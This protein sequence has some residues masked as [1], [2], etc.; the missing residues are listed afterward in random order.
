[1]STFQ[2]DV[3]LINVPLA[4]TEG[5]ANP[6]WFQFFIQL[7]RRTGGAQ[8]S[9]TT[10]LRLSDID[11]DPNSIS[12]DLQS[13]LGSLDETNTLL[14]LNAGDSDAPKL[15]SS[16][17]EASTLIRTLVVD[18]GISPKQANLLSKIVDLLLILEEAQDIAKKLR[19]TIEDTVIDG[20]TPLDPIRSMG[21]QDAAKVTISGGS[22]DGTSIGGNTQAAG[23]FT[24]LTT[25]G[26]AAVA[27]TPSAWGSGY[28]AIEVGLQGN[29]YFS[30]TGGPNYDSLLTNNAYYNGANW[31]YVRSTAATNIEQILGTIRFFTA[32]VGVAGNTITFTQQMLI[33]GNG[34]FVP[35]F[36][37][38]G[39]TPTVAAGSVGLG[40][41][42]ST[43]VGAAG[44]AAALP[45]TPT[46]YLVFNL[47]GTAFKLPYYN[48]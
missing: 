24:T 38:T 29:S 34:V 40:T 45:A 5:R 44:A 48:S 11:I 8:G 32:P 1:M 21:Y 3:P 19:K 7:W 15:A 12:A 14:Q 13:A 22:I 25:T 37:I 47:G 2:T 46:G 16:I 43:T 41:T 26:N 23:A 35:Q 20:M 17:N 18:D 28:R 33:N 36:I 39:A 10:D 4:T 6:I 27:T 31:I 30:A 42:T 9:S